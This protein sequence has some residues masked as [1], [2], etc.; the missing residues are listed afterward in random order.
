MERDDLQAILDALLNGGTLASIRATLNRVMRE[1]SDGQLKIY[2][3]PVR[4]ILG[5]AAIK[6]M[7]DSTSIVLPSKSTPY[8]PLIAY[9]RRRIG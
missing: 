4:A 7:D 3:A 5:S 9:C 6:S 1:S 8:G 2:L